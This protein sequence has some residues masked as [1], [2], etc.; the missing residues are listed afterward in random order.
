MLHDIGF[1]ATEMQLADTILSAYAVMAAWW[2]FSLFAGAAFVQA[3]SDATGDRGLHWPNRELNIFFTLTVGIAVQIAVLIVLAA[4][5]S[6]NLWALSLAAATLVVVS[7]WML[8]KAPPM[9][10]LA[11]ILEK[12][13]WGGFFQ[14]APLLLLFSAWVIPPLG[15][16]ESHDE[17]SY[18][19]P[20]ARFYLEQGGLAVHENLRFPL[21]THNF[22][23]L[24]AVA[25]LRDGP[26]TAHLIHATAGILAL[27]G[28]HGLVRHWIPQRNLGWIAAFIAVLLVLQVGE[29]QQG[30]GN[31]YVDLGFALFIVAAMVAMALWHENQHRTWLILAALF[32]GTAVG[33]KYLGLVFTVPLGLWVLLRSRSP[34][35]FL[36]FTCITCFFGLFW[37]LRSWWISGNPVHPFAGEWFGYY[38]WSP[39]QLVELMKELR[40]HGIERT[41]LNFWR[42]P[43]QLW[44]NRLVFSGSVDR[45]GLL[46]GAF[47]LNLLSLPWMRPALRIV[48]L[49]TFGYLIFWFCSAQIQRYLLP[50]APLM[51]LAVV[52]GLYAVS[53]QL[54]SRLLNL[55]GRAGTSRVALLLLPMVLI[56]VAATY[57][58]RHLRRDFYQTAIT[59]ADQEQHLAKYVAGYA[60]FKAA[61]ADVRIGNGPLMQFGLE[62]SFYYFPGALYGDWGGNFAYLD[63]METDP[64]GHLKLREPLVL[65]EQLRPDHI[66]GLVFR[67]DNQPFFR[68]RD[69][70]AFEQ[71]FETVFEDEFAIVM[72]P[73]N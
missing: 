27:L 16:A 47:Y 54:P 61:A 23:L 3:L 38:I 35:E 31:A 1:I 42:L 36:R 70:A 62:G 9:G 30:L 8:A 21:H 44:M 60:A 56:L 46:I 11:A 15:P 53:T 28:V 14:A 65:R 24:F 66:R 2:L 7:A 41:V 22:N 45:D 50:A 51:S 55:F 26:A 4:L 67:K 34:R 6:L 43:E 68:P 10:L 17:L 40:S 49:I 33:T 73:R 5:Q 63:Y 69:R 13:S 57:S 64:G 37:Y 72:V 71:V 20:Y 39:N 52:C 59:P 29:F 58:T 32:L 19:L 48:C 12:T 18:H 25:L